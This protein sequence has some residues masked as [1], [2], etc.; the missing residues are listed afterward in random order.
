MKEAKHCLFGRRVE[1]RLTHTLL[2]DAQLRGAVEEIV[3]DVVGGNED[4]V[5]R[6]D[7]LV[8]DNLTRVDEIAALL[9]AVRRPILQHA[10]TCSASLQPRFSC[11]SA[12]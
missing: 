6:V 1:N 10:S 9:E 11:V 12:S 5:L 3:R 4:E 8:E 7:D 2:S